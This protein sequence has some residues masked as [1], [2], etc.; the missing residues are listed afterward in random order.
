MSDIRRMSKSDMVFVGVKL[1]VIL[2]REIKASAALI[3]KSKQEFTAE[4]LALG[5]RAYKAEGVPA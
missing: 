2:D 4:L 5:L 1:P 3:G